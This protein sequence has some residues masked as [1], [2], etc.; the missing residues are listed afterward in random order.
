MTKLHEY[1]TNIKWTGKTGKG[2]V[3]YNNYERSHTISVA[4]KSV[5]EGSS[6]PSF[7][8]DASKHNPEELFLS[9]IATCHMLWYLHLCAEAG[10]VVTDYQDHAEG[11]MQENSDGSGQFIAVQLNPRVIIADSSKSEVAHK[12]HENANKY[13]FIANSL[14]FK[15]THHATCTHT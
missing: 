3:D 5:I 1:H 11:I 2:T 9:A 7:R 8:G 4:N 14:N 13:C 6:D 10:I 12:L 15:V